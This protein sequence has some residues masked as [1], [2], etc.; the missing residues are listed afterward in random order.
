MDITIIKNSQT[1]TVA[2]NDRALQ[3]G[4]GFFTTIKV[5]NGKPCLLEQH[6]ARL[7]RC[8]ARLY[9]DNVD[10]S[11]IE[12][13]INALANGHSL[14][15]IKVIVS[16]GQ[17]GRG[18]QLPTV[19]APQVYIYTSDFPENYLTLKQQGIALDTLSTQLAINPLLAGLK[20]LNRLEQVLA[21]Q[22]LQQKG[23]SEG[24]LLNCNHEVIETTVA[25]IVL[26]KNGQLI[27]PKLDKSGVFGVYLAHLA[28]HI[29]IKFDTVSLSD[30]Y[31]ADNLFCC[32]SLM[33]IV[34][35]T[36][37]DTH[38]YSLENALQFLNEQAL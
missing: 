36:R 13:Q 18:Y 25:N 34:P 10:L 26:L 3:Y 20:T 21:K 33:G 24:L 6:L 22:E 14:A 38:Y 37:L 15:V 27:T 19:Q 11:A 35:I 5:E 32:N 8:V 30:C 2:S 1:Q 4:D 29:D 28:K 12:N 31:S 17:G 16:R 23:V 7:A 9:F